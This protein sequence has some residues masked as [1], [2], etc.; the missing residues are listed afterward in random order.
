[1]VCSDGKSSPIDPLY[2]DNILLCYRL[3][4]GVNDAL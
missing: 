3:S 1:L 4:I 2:D